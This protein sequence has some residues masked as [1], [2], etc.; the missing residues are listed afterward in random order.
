MFSRFLH[1]PTAILLIQ[2]KSGIGENFEWIC[3][4]SD[5]YRSH[6][7][8]W[9]FKN[10]KVS[11]KQHFGYLLRLWQSFVFVSILCD[12]GNLLPLYLSPLCQS[13]ATL[14]QSST[15]LCQS[16][17]NLLP[18][19]CQSSAAMLAMFSNA[20]DPFQPYATLLTVCKST[21][22]LPLWQSFASLFVF[23]HHANLLPPYTANLLPP[24][25]HLL[26]LWQSSATQPSLCHSSHL[27]PLC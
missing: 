18:P 15:T 1:V 13:S 21:N 23:C 11:G 25:C 8:L 16:F 14:C 4:V 7:S 26:L 10:S 20:V 6:I 27:M 22:H 19:L 17:A 5:H 2:E 24:C 3:Q 9:T 12:P